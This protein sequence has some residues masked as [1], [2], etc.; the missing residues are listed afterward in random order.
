MG[1]VNALQFRL[2]P[3]ICLKCLE[4][5]KHILRNGGLMINYHGAKK[6]NYLNQIQH[7]FGSMVIYNFQEPLH[8]EKHTSLDIRTP[9]DEVFGPPTD[10]L[11]TS[12]EVFGCLRLFELIISEMHLDVAAPSQPCGHHAASYQG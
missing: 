2:Y 11:N 9:A 4:K 5:V 6:T 8:L 12:Q 7:N 3:W 1:Q 10:T